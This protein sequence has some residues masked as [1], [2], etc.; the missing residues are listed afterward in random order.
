M[1]REDVY[2]LIDTERAYQDRI[3]QDQENP[4][5]PNPLSIGEVVLLIEEYTAKARAQWTIEKK[6]EVDT[7]DIIRKIAGVTV[8]AMEQH[9][10]RPRE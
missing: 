2:K 9:G 3:W 5:Q 7:M 6:P 4:G 8:R 10:A 1:N